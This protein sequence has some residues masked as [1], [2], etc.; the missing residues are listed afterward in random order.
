[1]KGPRL[2]NLPLDSVI[3]ISRSDRIE[4][5]YNQGLCLIPLDKFSGVPLIKYREYEEQQN[6]PSRDQTL[7][8]FAG[9]EN[10]VA[11]LL[12]SPS[13]FTFCL[14]D[15]EGIL[16]EL[17][18]GNLDAL[19]TLR[20]I[21]PD[22]VKSHL[23]L[24]DRKCSL[25]KLDFR[26]CA[27]GV[28]SIQAEIKGDRQ[29]VTLAPSLHRKSHL[30]YQT[31]SPTLAIREIDGVIDLLIQKVMELGWR[32]SAAYLHYQQPHPGGNF[33]LLEAHLTIISDL[34]RRLWKKGQRNLLQTALICWLV[35]IGASPEQVESFAL[36]LALKLAR[37]LDQESWCSAT[38]RREIKT[39]IRSALNGNRLYGLAT[40]LSMSNSSNKELALQLLD[41]NKRI[42][43]SR[44]V[45]LEIRGWLKRR[46]YNA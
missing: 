39:A 13:D 16:G 38:Q 41:L 8:W 36:D 45:S 43:S 42:R 28:R 17:T 24:K 1:M 23:F 31:A 33:H 35:R 10:G 22:P 11:V 7:R 30:P 9:K 20:E 15:D 40:L 2:D 27:H 18:S 46:G 12:G 5:L 21:G 14:D 34:V 37:E 32:P 3:K 6:R 19:R 25:G 44:K 4:L 26:L 29:L